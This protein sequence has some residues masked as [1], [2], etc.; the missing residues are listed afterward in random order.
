MEFTRQEY[1][2][3]LLFPSPGDLPDQE[4]ESGS[5]EL[6]AHSVPSESLGNNTEISHCAVSV[7]LKTV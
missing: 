1:C 6:Q 4:T 3:G 5:L 7:D 2:S